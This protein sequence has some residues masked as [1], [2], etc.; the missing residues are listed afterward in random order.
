M[1]TLMTIF[2]KLT[3]GVGCT[4]PSAKYCECAHPRAASPSKPGA[5]PWPRRCPGPSKLSGP[6][7]WVHPLSAAELFNPMIGAMTRG[8]TNL[9]FQIAGP[10]L[11]MAAG[12]SHLDPERRKPG[13]SRLLRRR[14]PLS[15]I[16]ATWRFSTTS[17]RTFL[18]VIVVYGASM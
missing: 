4:E 17:Y 2:Q 10:V 18:I 3:T 13:L 11:R 16:P 5:H 1:I 7:R 14:S 8:N 9:L 12:C 6:A 15:L